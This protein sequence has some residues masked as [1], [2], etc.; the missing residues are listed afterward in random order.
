MRKFSF[1]NR[2]VQKWNAL[3]LE[4]KLAKDVNSFKNMLDNNEQIRTIF[5]EYDGIE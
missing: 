2:V 1:T 4:I 5:F 3:P